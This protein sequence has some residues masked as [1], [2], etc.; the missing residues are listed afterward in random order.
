MSK[1]EDPG[2]SGGDGSR[3]GWASLEPLVSLSALGV[4]PGRMDVTGWGCPS[5]DRAGRVALGA[6]R[7][8]VVGE[9]P[10]ALEAMRC[11]GR[12][13]LF[14]LGAPEGDSRRRLLRV[15]RVGRLS[16]P[17]GWW[18]LAGVVVPGR[19]LAISPDPG[20]VELVSLATVA[21]ALRAAGL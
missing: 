15:D 1:R 20:R 7:A 14:A 5:V 17:P 21:E 9:V 2:L 6:L 11:A 8:V 16:V 3:G 4:R 12:I 13:S 18:A 19:V 10:G